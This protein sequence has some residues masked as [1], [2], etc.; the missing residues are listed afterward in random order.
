MTTTMYITRGLPGSGKTFWARRMLELH[1]RPIVRFNR[2]DLRAMA[3]PEGYRQPEYSSEARISC[4]RDAGLAATLNA[5]CDVI[6]DDTNLRS[7]YVK[8]L[9]DIAAR[10]GA[11]VEFVEFTDVSLEECIRRDALRPQP[12]GEDV[13]RSM[14]QR[15]LA[16]HRGATLP[17]PEMSPIAGVPE[18]YVPEPDLPEIFIVDVDGT[19]AL[20]DRSPYDETRVLTDRPN[21]KVILAVKSMIA[22]GY[23]PVF[24]SGRTEGCR[25]DT[26]AWFRVYMAL[27]PELYMRPI[28]DTRPDNVVKLELFDKHIRHQYHVVLVFDD[29]RNVVRMWRS[30]GLTCLQVAEGDF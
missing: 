9:M 3:L 2:D 13:I 1:E 17:I 10:A 7:K 11:H 23:R 26:E 19:I 15:Y 5:G 24:M 6:V 16:Q 21:H 4:L 25:K 28:G 27:Q 14:H 29:R 8:S 30:L 12:V 18:L 20:L 22:A